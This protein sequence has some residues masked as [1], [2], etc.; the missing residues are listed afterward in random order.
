MAVEE[1]AFACCANLAERNADSPVCL[2]RTL[3]HPSLGSPELNNERTSSFPGAMIRRALS[4]LAGLL[5]VGLLAVPQSAETIRVRYAEGV[6]HGFLV[7]RDEAGTAIADG[8]VQQ[9]AHGNT[10]TAHLQLQFKD[11]SSYDEVTVFSQRG[12]FRLL[13]DKV[14][15]E[16]PAFK[17]P[18]ETDIDARSGK[19]TLRETGK[20][21]ADTKQ[22]KLP[23]D[24]ANGLIFILLKNLAPGV[25]RTSFSMVASPSRRIIKLNVS[26]GGESAVALGILRNQARIYDI[27][28]EIQGVAG[29]V[30]PIVGKKPPDMHVWILRGDAPGFVAS[31]GPLE[32]GGPIWRIEF[33]SPEVVR[34]SDSESE[35][36][37]KKP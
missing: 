10:V 3:T 25:T 29:I 18:G 31:E 20:A 28:F 12:V 26:E 19:V 9:V 6:T 14:Q 22:M 16:G 8:Q 37:H 17:H 23:A 24:I 13:S 27:K 32:D 33:A 2:P 21:K 35:K 15:Q 5:A 34:S 11:G 4:L 36:Q 30:A 1:R 7:L